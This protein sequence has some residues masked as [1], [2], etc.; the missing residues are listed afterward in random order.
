RS[1]DVKLSHGGLIDTEFSLQKYC[2]LNEIFPEQVS[3]GSILPHIE[4]DHDLKNKILE[5]YTFLRKFEQS[6][7]ICTGSSR[8]KVVQQDPNL[9]KVSHLMQT[10]EVGQK[11]ENTLK[12]Q[13]E[14]LKSLD[15]NH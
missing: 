15:L 9:A 2:L 5:N 13:R 8:T 6:Y 4:I 14:L 7:Q 10:P 1:V 3:V 11:L 12:E